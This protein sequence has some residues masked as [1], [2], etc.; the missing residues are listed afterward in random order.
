M[1]EVD[2]LPAE[3]TQFGRSQAM[4][5]IELIKEMLAEREA[6]ANAKVI[7]RRQQ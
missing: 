6:G 4:W 2:L 7:E 1:G 5:S 3:G